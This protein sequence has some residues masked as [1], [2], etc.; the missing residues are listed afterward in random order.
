MQISIGRDKKMSKS[1][2]YPCPV[3]GEMCMSE[4]SGSFDICPVC[5][6]EEDGYQQRHPDET[7]ANGKWTLNKAKETWK[8]GKT[9]FESFPN[10]NAK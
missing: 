9:L 2:K 3:C 7:G 5:G 1:V 8:R 6:W 10:P 4:P